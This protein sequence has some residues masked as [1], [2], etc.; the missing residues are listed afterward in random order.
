[1]SGW[2]VTVGGVGGNIWHVIGQ[3]PSGMA[4]VATVNP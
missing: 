3:S 2:I 1:M 4:E